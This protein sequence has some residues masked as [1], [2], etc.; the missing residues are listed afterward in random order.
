MSKHARRTPV[1]LRATLTALVAIATGPF[2]LAQAVAQDASFHQAP[3]SSVIASNPLAGQADAARAGATVYEQH[4]ASCH[5]ATAEG[6]GNIPALNSARIKQVAEGELFWFITHGSVSSGMPSWVNLP[7][8]QR[9]QLVSLLK[10]ADLSSQLAAA[11]KAKPAASTSVLD[12]PKP[13]APFTDFRYESPGTA[14][15]ITVADLP[16]PFATASAGNGPT[17]IPRPADAVPKAPP[18]FKV[19]LYAEQLHNPRRMLTA[20]NGDV[21]VAETKAGQLTVFRGLGPDGK[22]VQRKIFIKGLNEP[23][24]LAFYPQGP[25]PQWLYIGDTDAVLRVAYHD[26]DMTA[27][28]AP[29]HIVDLPHAPGH[30]TRDVRFSLDGKRMFVSVGSA[31][32]VDDPDTT[33]A[34]KNRADILVF[35]PDGSD[36]KIYAWGIRNASGLA[37]HPKTGELWCTVNE[38]DGLGDNLV[39]DYITHVAEGGFYGWPWWYMG[40][41]QDPRHAG[42]HPELAS[43]AIMPDVLLQP[44]N[45]SLQ[46]LFYEGQQFPAEYRGD[47]FATE[48][49]SW[50]KATRTGYEVIRLP[51]DGKGRARGGYEDFVTGFVLPDGQVW[52][53]PVG[54]TI[55]TDGSMLISDDGSNAIW[56]V[57]YTGK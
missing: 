5:G 12:A 13:Q 23:Y 42:K 22:P 38:R 4:C 36:M 30:S 7:E 18:G 43:R 27:S 29:E 17:L 9:W 52:G 51:M 45:A 47:A 6:A 19:A 57:S 24:G 56:R 21:F 28:G 49:G 37:V 55:A 33:P 34:E 11:T 46:M 39:P 3:P 44:H 2:S 25:H 1:H 32:N 16:S 31:S 26:G 54:I 48:H 14:R 15:K 20:P 35:R 40:A 50:N 10:S 8:T 53:R 41:H